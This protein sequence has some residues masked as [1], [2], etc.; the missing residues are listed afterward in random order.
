MI[1]LG[2]VGR[3]KQINKMLDATIKVEC[4]RKHREGQDEL[5]LVKSEKDL[6][7]VVAQMLYI[8][9]EQALAR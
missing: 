8:G 4:C 7:E 1:C 6:A 3:D 2:T 5:S 9:H